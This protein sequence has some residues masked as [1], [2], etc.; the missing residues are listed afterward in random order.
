MQLGHDCR[1][2][3]HD[4]LQGLAIDLGLQNQSPIALL[5]QLQGRLELPAPARGELDRGQQAV[6]AELGQWQRGLQ[7]PGPRP[8]LAVVT[9]APEQPGL[10]DLHAV[11]LALEER[12][13]DLHAL[14]LELDPGSA[15]P[16]LAQVQSIQRHP[17]RCYR[18]HA[19]R[20]DIPAGNG[21]ALQL[22]HHP[23]CAPCDPGRESQGQQQ[24]QAYGAPADAAWRYRTMTHRRA[25]AAV[26]SKGS[27]ST[28]SICSGCRKRSA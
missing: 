5:L 1:S 20:I 24:H 18:T 11:D 12:E 16:L 6:D 2:G 28:G 14:Q 17:A 21:A 7:Q 25:P 23:A 22:L 27:I 9:G 13:I 15:L 26:A 8:W 3:P 10:A 19:H 4:Q